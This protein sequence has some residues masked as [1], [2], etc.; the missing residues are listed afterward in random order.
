[1]WPD[2]KRRIIILAYCNRFVFPLAAM[3]VPLFIKHAQ[4]L[5]YG[6]SLSFLALYN[7]L[8]TL[9]RCKHVYCAH[10]DRAHQKMTP[11]NIQWDRVSFSDKY[12]LPIVFAVLAVVCFLC[13]AWGK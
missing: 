5:G 6:I 1:M 12:G 13:F 10:Q 3:F 11:E 4:L 9:F 8:G 2:E 7:I